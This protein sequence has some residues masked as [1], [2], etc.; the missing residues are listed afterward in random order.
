[1]NLSW[2]FRKGL[3]LWKADW[4]TEICPVSLLKMRKLALDDHWDEDGQTIWQGSFLQ[5]AWKNMNVW[6][7]FC[8][9]FFF[10]YALFST[11][12]TGQLRKF[13][14]RIAICQCL[15]IGI[16]RMSRRSLRRRIWFNSC[17][18]ENRNK[19]IITFRL[20]SV[21]WNPLHIGQSTPDV[22]ELGSPVFVF[23]FWL[24]WTCKIVFC[25]RCKRQKNFQ[26]IDHA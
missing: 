25:I 17:P 4:F 23:K 2:W 19:D 5:R 14:R 24:V 15:S 18:D 7:P 13:R 22:P 20:Q 1:M 12:V 10:F 11:L 3:I 21:D 6:E 8:G 9:W 16:G 26:K